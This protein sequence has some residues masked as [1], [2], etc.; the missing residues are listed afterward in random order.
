MMAT[1]KKASKKSP[2]K[3]ATKSAPKK[4]SATKSTPAKAALAQKAAPAKKSPPKNAPAK[5][6]T[7]TQRVVKSVEVAAGPA[8]AGMITSW[9]PSIGRGV[10][11]IDNGGGE[12]A[13]DLG[14]TA[15]VNKG[16]VDLHVGRKVAY[17]QGDGT[18]SSL[19]AT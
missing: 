1:T 14:R 19:E 12:Y 11:R 9:N 15:I 6:A 8:E 7:T 13:F 5:K 17:A 2:S 3:A 16:Y 18:D 4:A 10:V